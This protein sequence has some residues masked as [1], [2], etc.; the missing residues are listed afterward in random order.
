MESNKKNLIVTLANE[1][2]LEQAKQLF[3]GVF[4]NAGWKGDYLL[5]AHNVAPE[6]LKWFK[7]NGIKIYKTKTINKY[8]GPGN[9]PEVVLSKLYLFKE[10]FKKWNKIIY[11]DADIIVRASLDKLLETKYF[12][13]PEG[14]EP[15]LKKQFTA[16]KKII[17]EL[18]LNQDYNLNSRAFLS[19]IFCFD[20]KLI[21][22]NTFN[23]LVIMQKHYSSAC[24]YG[25]E[26]I[27]NIFFYKK[28]EKLP[29]IYNM[30]PNYLKRH[31]NLKEAEYLAAIIHFGWATKPW[32]KV[33]YF[34]EEW[35]EN[36]RNAEAI[37]LNKRPDAKK[38][39]GDAELKRFLKLLYFKK[40]P[41]TLIFYLD[42]QVGKTGLIVK[43]FFPS[44]Y[45]K[46]KI[47]KDDK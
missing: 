31:F 45:E 37:N 12:S 22:T 18:R 17:E 11:L 8:T 35:Q 13:S 24:N 47:I 9:Y 16:D 30:Q 21:T 15:Y 39:I 43:K 36:Y 1:G 7:N 4:Y 32:N 28:W 3:A 2:Y 29:I 27:L 14:E 19:G 40:Y 20:T 6:K 25:E 42:R 26:P 10:Y 5:L 44:F 46:I 33:S 38:V 41:N 23:S 34:H